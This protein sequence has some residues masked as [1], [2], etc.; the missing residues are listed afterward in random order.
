MAIELCQRS[1]LNDQILE[2]RS[3]RGVYNGTANEYRGVFSSSSEQSISFLSARPAG[4]D[5]P[6]TPVYS[7]FDVRN[8]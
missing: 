4:T 3:F 1:P 7:H 8:Q 5:G 6:F 2:V